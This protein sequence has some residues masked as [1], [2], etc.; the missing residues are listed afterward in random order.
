[1]RN[2]FIFFSMFII[3]N[4]F[5]QTSSALIGKWKYVKLSD[6]KIVD[7]LGKVYAEQMFKDFS[8]YLKPN[9]RYVSTFIKKEDGAWSFDEQTDKLNFVATKGTISASK[10]KMIDANTIHFFMKETDTDYIILTKTEP[11][12]K[13]K[14]E[15]S[16]NEYQLMTVSKDALCKKWS[17][18]SRENPETS[19]ESL[20]TTNELFANSITFEFTKQ[21]VFKTVLGNLK[22]ESTWKLNV[23]KNTI[24]IKDGNDSK[25]WQ[26]LKI[27]AKELILVKG[28]SN[29]KWIFSSMK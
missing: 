18:Q 10:I 22:T 25:T 6:E 13:D 23:E 4:T 20:A 7:S 14:I 16:I 1:M 26:V 27:N 2:I 9:G 28:N 19:K 11:S 8:I 3:A 12:A 15:P 17:L 29:E 21:N 5:A 24:I